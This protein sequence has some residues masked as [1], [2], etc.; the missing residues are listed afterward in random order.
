MTSASSL[1]LKKTIVF[2]YFLGTFLKI[3][4]I[5]IKNDSKLNIIN[6]KYFYKI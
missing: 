6:K 5:N 2:I 3:N 1:N 4:C